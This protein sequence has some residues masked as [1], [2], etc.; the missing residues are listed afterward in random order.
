MKKLLTIILLF[1]F[2]CPKC[3]SGYLGVI[4]NDPLGNIFNV[5]FASADSTLFTRNGSSG[6]WTYGSGSLSI[7]GTG[8]NN[9]NNNIYYT[10]WITDLEKSSCEI[11]FTPTGDGSGIGLG[12]AGSNGFDMIGR[13]ILTGAT[14][15]QL[16]FDGGNAASV[17]HATSSTL[18]SV[19]NGQ[20]HK[21]TLTRTPSQV[22]VTILNTV[23]SATLTLT[24]NVDFTTTAFDSYKAGNIGVFWYGGSQTIT[25]FRYFSTMLKQPRILFTGDSNMQGAYAGSNDARYTIELGNA[26]KNRLEV[27]S[28]GGNTSADIVKLL[29]EILLITPQSVFVNIGTN[30]ITQSDIDTIRNRLT[31][32]NIKVFLSTI[33]PTTSGVDGQNSII[34]GESGVTLIDFDST[35]INGG[36][37]LYSG[38]VTT[39]NCCHLN[40][41]GNMAVYTQ[42]FLNLTGYLTPN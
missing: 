19:T 26:V 41:T 23:T 42:L 4:S 32:N 22:F 40:S 35:L 6:V 30:G 17:N 37:V 5:A 27:V 34:R 1:S 13:I 12:F 18:F 20:Q 24:Y 14:K 15:G 38:Y 39:G 31:R 8:Q 33:F 16:R 21:L 3:Q 25:N 10:N 7:S 2:G 9:S 36:S 29:P 28:G 11:I